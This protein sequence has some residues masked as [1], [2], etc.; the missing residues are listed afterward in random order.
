MI[1]AT[2]SIRPAPVTGDRE[3]PAHPATPLRTFDAAWIGLLTMVISIAGSPRP[4]LWFDEAATISAS[5]RTV[6]ELWRMLGN[7]DAVHGLYY[8]IMHWWFAVFPASE[9]WSRLSSALAV[10]CAAAGV[11]VLAR[12]LASR[13]VAITAGVVFAILPRVTW[14]GI[15]TRSYALS[16]VVA[17]WMTVLLLEAVR[18]NRPRWWLAYS[19]LT[20]AGGLLNVFLVLMVPVH[21]VVVA[22][23]SPSR[24]ARRAWVVSACLSLAA[25]T[26][27][28]L[29]TQTQLFQVRWITT[30]TDNPLVSITRDQYFDHAVV[31][32]ILAGAAIVAG[33]VAVPRYGL[34]ICD[35]IGRAH[36]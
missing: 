30:L 25:I 29:F 4:S 12:K 19:A 35:Q 16:M 34:M 36:V 3:E 27:F 10:A 31:F 15:E 33:L 18:R 13:S 14:A 23:T 7:I 5:T 17:V 9:F 22:V 8:L 21:A 20:I 24:S 2:T 28:L 32:A 11:V 1:S 26:P 6:P